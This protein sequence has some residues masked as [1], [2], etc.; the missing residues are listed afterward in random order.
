MFGAS[1][2]G[3]LVQLQCPHCNAAQARARE[4]A[5]HVYRCRDCHRSFTREE[6]LARAAEIENARQPRRR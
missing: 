3:A 5:G 4:K 2:R 1:S 6:G